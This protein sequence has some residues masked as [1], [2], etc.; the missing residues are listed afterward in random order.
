[1][2]CINICQG[3][4]VCICLMLTARALASA[5][6]S[7]Q[8]TF[9]TGAYNSCLIQDRDGLI[10][11]SCSNGIVRYDGYDIKFIKSGEGLLS[12]AIASCIFEDD[13]GLLWIATSAGLNRFDKKTNTFTVYK[14]DPADPYSISSGQFN[15]APRT[16]AQDRDGGMWFGTQAGVNRLDK[17][18][19]RFT[20]FRHVPGDADSLSHDSVWTV[21]A[22]K[23]GVIWIGTESGLDAFSPETKQV[24]R[25]TH[26][27]DCPSSIGRGRIYAV[28]EDEWPFVWVGTSLGGLNRLNRETGRFLRF[29]HSPGSAG[30]L[31]HNAILTIT[32]DRSGLLWLGRPY[33]VA[34]GLE[35][36]DPKTLKFTVHKHVE[37]DA[38]SIFGDIIMGCYQ[39]RSGIMWI[40]ENTGGID[41]WDPHWKPFEQYCHR[42]G[43]N[44]GPSSNVITTIAESHDGSLWM[45]TQLGGLNRLDRKTGRFR[46]YRKNRQ[47]PFGISHDYVFSVLEDQDNNLWI[48]MNNGVIGLFNPDS[49]RLEKQ[50]INPYTNGVARGMIQDR[51]SPD[52]LW[53][54]TEGDGMF[55]LNKHS[56]KFT[57]FTHDPG[58]ENS[59]ANN[60]VPR[61]FQE[62]DG[63]LWVATLGGGLDRFVPGTGIFVHHRK[64][65]K[66]PWSISGDMVTDCHRD[67]QGR[68]WVATGDGGLNRLDP[69][70]GRFT[71][72]GASQ[73]FETQT[74]RAILEDNSENLW[75]STDSGL[76]RFSLTSEQVT[77]RFTD[78]DGLLGNNFSL[79]AT[80]AT[81]TRDGKLWF[82][83]LEGVISFFPDQI[84]N[85][86]YIPPVVLTAFDVSG[87][88][89]SIRACPETI[90]QVHL[91]WRNNSFE[92]EFAA[93]N[94]TQPLKNKYAYIL[95]G[96]DSEWNQS[97]TRRYG[98]YTNLPCGSYT[99]RLAGSNNDGVWNKNQTRIEVHVQRPPWKTPLAYGLYGALVLALC[100]WGRNLTAKSI[101]KRLAAKEAE[102]RKEKK[103][104]DQLKAI[105]KINSD[106]LEKKALVEN[107][108][109][110]NKVKLE[111]M[112]RER[113]AE[114]ESE[115]EKAE[116]A[117]R[118]K[119]EFLANM[120]HEIRTPLNLILGYAEMIEKQCRDDAIIG[121]I[122][123]IRSAG[124]TLLTLLNDILDLSKAESGKFTVAYAPFNLDSLLDEIGQI[125]SIT[126]EN[127]GVAFHLE[128]SGTLPAT[129]ILDK[130]R[131]RQ[132]LMNIV[133]NAVKFTNEGDVKLR[134]DFHQYD[135]G[136]LFS[137]LLFYV[138]DTGIGIDPDQEGLI[139]EPFSQQKGQDFNTYGGTGIGLSISKKLVS[140]MGG[141]ITLESTPGL[142][143]K[144]IISIPNVNILDVPKRRTPDLAKKAT[145]REPEAARPEPDL[146]PE[147]LAALPDLLA[148]LKNELTPRWKE[149]RN[150]LVISRVEGFSRD[151]ADLGSQYQYDPL[152]L[153]AQQLQT[154]TR[155]FDMTSLPDTLAQ[156]LGIISELADRINKVGN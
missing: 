94:Y 2:R 97:G 82:A 19:G 90:E 69:T 29:E 123:T 78:Q 148:H 70:S 145:E 92:F 53:F 150:G 72:Y 11:V 79:F 80:S 3:L 95:E 10:W 15:W 33:D 39:D 25:F 85:N 5:E 117:S 155:E 6:F 50:F 125:F 96:F 109:R 14:N 84:K 154:L 34:A 136:H 7:V 41:K 65:E 44:T 107:R 13:Q 140:A 8:H 138:E 83:S 52:I 58:N 134:A 26:D 23:D 43:D 133:G 17:A 87:K 35:R 121:D 127:K 67:S 20:R 55:R 131:L 112:V 27:P 71:H 103:I 139:F 54:G 37:D 68:L 105:D 1:M 113:T 116:A 16:I 93:L 88:S 59:L 12:S 118:A 30:S 89:L 151:A 137:K 98:S 135:R 124:A 9:N 129:I 63:I 132:I 141:V 38:Q 110:N 28:L 32:K 120:S 115:K 152:T 60:M 61:L 143:S 128:K 114:L 48:S 86:P 126:A 91:D 76:L 149:L 40:I 24:T 147:I 108:L 156:F 74:I 101:K 106:L 104:N 144:F 81:K 21:V 119:S 51:H 146:S 66:N 46:V 142:G 36:F 47:K 57:R 102:L 18:T 77:G 122:S 111:N 4:F 130:T 62:A 64:D 56:G 31:S 22:G 73:G 45:G 42:E 75:L 99:L 153:W 100:L 49:A